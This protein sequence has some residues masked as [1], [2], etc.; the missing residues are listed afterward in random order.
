MWFVSLV[1]LCY[2]SQSFLYMQY[3]KSRRT[4]LAISQRSITKDGDYVEHAVLV[5]LVAESGVSAD[6]VIDFSERLAPA[7]A[8]DSTSLLQVPSGH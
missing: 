5:S 4:R 2:D 8:A 7:Q 1:S 6:G 3:G